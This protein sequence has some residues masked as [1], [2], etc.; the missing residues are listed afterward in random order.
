MCSEHYNRQGSGKSHLLLMHPLKYVINDPDFNGVFFRRV[1]KQLKGPG[2]LW[3]ESQKMYQRFKVDTKHTS[4]THKFPGGGEL[5][6]AHLEHEQDKFSWQ[7]LQL[8]CLMMDELTH[9]SESQYLYLLSRLRS[10]AN[11][12]SYCMATMNP[13][14]RSW[15]RDWVDWWLDDEGYPEPSKQGVVRYYLLVEDKPVFADTEEELKKEYPHLMYVNNPLTGEDVY[16]P[17]KTFTFVFGNIWDNPALIAKNP[18]YLAELNSLPEIEKARLLHGSW[19]AQPMGSQLFQREWVTEVDAMPAKAMRVRSWDLA[20]SE[21]SDAYRNPDYSASI[22]MS[23]DYDGFY[24]IEKACKFRKRPGE[25]DAEIIIT[26]KQDTPE[27][28]VTIPRDPGSGG[29]SAAL[30]LSKKISEAGFVCR[31]I[32]TSNKTKT[33]RF[34]PFSAAAQSGLIRVVKSG[35]EP[36]ELEY[37]YRQ[38]EHFMGDGRGKDD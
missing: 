20:S 36:A 7:G 16:V 28:K 37:L 26:A 6:F 35:F 13:D 33:S 11:S 12:D 18:K 25:R 22:R 32:P 21:P 24:Y 5:T 30:D 31:Q 14:A 3:P 9:F 2:G 4:L 27:V 23:K 15:C 38:L 17:P 1:T 34:E 10:E 8:S 29:A 19:N